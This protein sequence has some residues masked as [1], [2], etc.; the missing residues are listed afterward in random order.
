MEKMEI[1]EIQM[2]TK[3]KKMILTKIKKNMLKI[4][5]NKKTHND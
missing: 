3:I 5:L 1:K 2:V 4:T